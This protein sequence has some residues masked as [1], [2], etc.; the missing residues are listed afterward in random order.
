MSQGVVIE[1]EQKDC[2]DGR[3]VMIGAILAGA[4]WWH[5]NYT[6]WAVPLHGGSGIPLGY[7]R[8]EQ[9]GPLLE[10]FRELLLTGDHG[11]LKVETYT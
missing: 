6:T 4:L 2:R 1:F 9:V 8:P 3:I 11:P 10:R 5:E 7:V